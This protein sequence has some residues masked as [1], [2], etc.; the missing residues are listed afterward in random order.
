MSTGINYP[1]STEACSSSAHT[2]RESLTPEETYIEPKV[3]MTG[4]VL[5]YSSR[6]PWVLSNRPAV[7]PRVTAPILDAIT[8]AESVAQHIRSIKSAEAVYVKAR[9][10]GFEY[11]IVVNDSSEEERFRLYDI[12]WDLMEQNPAVGF[13]FHLVD[14]QNQPLAD[15]MTL[16]AVDG[17]AKVRKA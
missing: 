7:S 16:E 1:S 2:I 10:W 12:E 13:K 4:A 5:V 6:Q 15:V 17:A 3:L 8:L 9:P 11:W 14:R